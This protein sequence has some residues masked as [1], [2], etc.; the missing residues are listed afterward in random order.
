MTETIETYQTLPTT[1]PTSDALDRLAPELESAR[2]YAVRALAPRTVETYAEQWRYFV[3]WCAGHGVEPL[4]AAPTTLA[5]YL[6]GQA[7]AGKSASTISVSAS[8]I[9]RAH[10]VAGHA[11]PSTHPMVRETAA[12]VRRVVLRAQKQSAPAEVADVR[13]MVAAL[14]A[15][16]SNG[17]GRVRDRALL[18]VGFACALRRGELVALDVADVE[19]VAAGMAVTVRQSKTD[20][21]GVGCVLSIRYGQHPE[22]CPVRALRAW[23][24]AA[25]IVDGAIFRSTKT[26][27]QIGDRVTSDYVARIVKKAATKAGIDASK[28]SW[29]SLRSGWATSAAKAG[30][31]DRA[32]MDRGRWTS[33]TTVDRYVR[34]AT[35]FQTSPD[36][37]VDL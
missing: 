25:G 20:Q 18:L 28:F 24:D 9:R 29:H 23:L 10:S 36:G 30:V 32:I 27:G 34:R 11:D 3:G 19:F 6:A 15:S 13:A 35:G 33:R 14:D 21:E 5:A 37:L 7:D 22:S 8:A 16:P 1:S 31:N 26:H 4:P 12:G 17:L 2:R